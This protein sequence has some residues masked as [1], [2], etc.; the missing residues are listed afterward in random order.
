MVILTEASRPLPRAAKGNVVRKL[1][2]DL[3]AEKVKNLSV[4]ETLL[5]DR[6]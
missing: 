3:Y 4:V 2:L 1:A 6:N 5:R